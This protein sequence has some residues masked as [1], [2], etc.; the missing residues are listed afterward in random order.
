M[1]RHDLV[2]T[3]F[4]KI[5]EWK[6]YVYYGL[7]IPTNKSCTCT[8]AV[9]SH[10]PWL[11]VSFQLISSSGKSP[12][13]GYGWTGAGLFDH[14]TAGILR[15]FNTCV[16]GEMV[17]STNRVQM[18]PIHAGPQGLDKMYICI[19]K[20][21]SSLR[22]CTHSCLSTVCAVTDVNPVIQ[23]QSTWSAIDHMLIS[24]ET[25]PNWDIHSFL[26]SLKQSQ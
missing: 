2:F 16:S 18:E 22:H 17:D 1:L 6:G 9:C 5:W 3:A 7:F 11:S 12:R 19:G 24:A 14:D 21:S 15:G 26:S 10:Q 4:N 20:C 23:A 8:V 25:V 13:V